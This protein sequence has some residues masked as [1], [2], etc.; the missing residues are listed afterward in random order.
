[1]GGST[2]TLFVP[3][4]E[5]GSA[6]CLL[7]P[8]NTFCTAKNSKTRGHIKKLPMQI[9]LSDT[10]LHLLRL[11]LPPLSSL[12]VSY[13]ANPKTTKPENPKK[14]HHIWSCLWIATL[15][16]EPFCTS[17]LQKQ[18]KAILKKSTTEIQQQCPEEKRSASEADAQ[19]ELKFYR[20]FK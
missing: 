14:Q 4:E 6:F 15:T 2:L 1:M 18:I 12:T 20:R 17:Q 7:I 16:Q 10:G 3:G 5:Y 19:N 13:K 8:E 11:R 9:L